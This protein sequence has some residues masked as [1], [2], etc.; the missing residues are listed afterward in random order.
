EDVFFYLCME[1]HD[2][3]QP[4]FG[5][6]YPTNQAFEAAMKSAYLGKIKQRQTRSET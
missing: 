6:E 4:V 2:L 5:Y 3:W 1:N